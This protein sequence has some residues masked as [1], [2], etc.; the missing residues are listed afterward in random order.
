MPP[1]VSDHESKT[2]AC[3][4]IHVPPSLSF[5]LISFS[6]SIRSSF[7]FVFFS[8]AT[9]FVWIVLF[10]LL[11]DLCR[12][13]RAVDEVIVTALFRRDKAHIF[14]PPYIIDRQPPVLPSYGIAFHSGLV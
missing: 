10:V 4:S 6:G 2:A 14:K 5:I 11:S 13:H 7:L 1:K 9:S 3:P 12:H 8:I